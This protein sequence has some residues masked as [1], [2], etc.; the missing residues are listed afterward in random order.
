LDSGLPAW[1]Q[2]TQTDDSTDSSAGLV[3][4]GRLRKWR[5]SFGFI[6]I[7]PEYEA[8]LPVSLDDLLY[9]SHRFILEDPKLLA[10]GDMLQFNVGLN[11]NGQSHAINVRHVDVRE[12][13]E[14]VD[15]FY[16]GKFLRHRK[17]GRSGVIRR[18]GDGR[19][20]V[21]LPEGLQAGELTDLAQGEPVEFRVQA[22]S[23]DEGHKDTRYDPA[24]M[25]FAV[26]ARRPGYRIRGVVVSFEDF[27]GWI[28][29]EGVGPDAFFTSKYALRRWS[30]ETVRFKVGD[31]LEYEV[32][33]KEKGPRAVDIKRLHSESDSP[34]E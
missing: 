24:A 8:S 11:D 2:G 21:V 23:R 6:Q 18:S 10:L 29:P 30:G 5:G 26:E 16:G 1:R 13:V 25:D 12:P 27:Q 9:V 31:V 28:R 15:G 19:E 20:F 14:A 17:M 34:G 4:R 32:K 3:F 22:I 33:M 7:L